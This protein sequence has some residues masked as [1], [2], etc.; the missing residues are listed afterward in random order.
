MGGSFLRPAVVLAP[1]ALALAGWC[2]ASGGPDW[3]L[4]RQL[5]REARQGEALERCDR[6]TRRCLLAKARVTEDV[7]AGGLTLDEAARRFGEITEAL[8][9][10]EGCPPEV[11]APGGEQGLC[12]NVLR[13]V[14]Q[15]PASSQQAAARARLEEEYRQRFGA[16]PPE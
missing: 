5:L 4:A 8:E 10:N 6:T 1:F 12:L 15:L 2:F 16:L 11:P 14:G 3:S 7:V 13:W 9:E